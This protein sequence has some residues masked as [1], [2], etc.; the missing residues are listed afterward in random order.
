MPPENIRVWGVHVGGR[1]FAVKPLLLCAANIVALD[2]PQLRSSDFISHEAVRL[3]QRLGFDVHKVGSGKPDRTLPSGSV[4]GTPLPSSTEFFSGCRAFEQR[5]KR[6]AM[7]KV[8][9]FLLEHFWNRPSDMAD[10]LG[11]LLLTWNQA[12]YRYGAF[13]FDKLEAWINDHLPELE[14]YRKRTI[15]TLAIA[16]DSPI[17]ALFDGL[18]DALDVPNAARSK[19]RRSPVA[20]AKA[21]HLLAPAFFPLWDLRIANALACRYSEQ[22]ARAYVAFCWKTKA[23]AEHVSPFVDRPEKTLLKLID[24]YNYARFTKGWI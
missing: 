15:A 14:S 2:A 20:A 13:D 4:D 11:V 22:P 12:F 8:A 18:L 24:E 6:D 19:G 17:I 21:L 10:A 1:A 9:T 5:E 7:Y 3:F 23:L 16:D